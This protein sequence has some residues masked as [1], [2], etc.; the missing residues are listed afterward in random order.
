[1]YVPFLSHYVAP[2]AEIGITYTV[3]DRGSFVVNG[4]PVATLGSDQSITFTPAFKPEKG[5]TYTVTAIANEQNG[6]TEQR[7]A[8]IRVA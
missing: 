6:H 2:G 5:H 1:M 8:L 3:F 7:T 4:Q